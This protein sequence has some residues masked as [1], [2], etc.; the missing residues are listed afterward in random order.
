MFQYRG[1]KFSGVINRKFC[2]SIQQS[3][4]YN[5]YYGVYIIK[6]PNNSQSKKFST[7]KLKQQPILFYLFKSQNYQ[8]EK[9]KLYSTYSLLDVKIPNFY[10]LLPT[11]SIVQL[12]T[13]IIFQCKTIHHNKNTTQKNVQGIVRR[14][15]HSQSINPNKIFYLTT[16]LF[17]K[18]RLKQGAIKSSLCQVFFCTKLTH[19][20]TQNQ[21]L[22]YYD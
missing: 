2:S 18:T 5:N 22:R 21:I 6:K 20:L 10:L 19:S 13:S 8:R 11:N 7:N 12:L 1:R 3:Y 17:I 14:N 16:K 9:Y 4:V 15:A